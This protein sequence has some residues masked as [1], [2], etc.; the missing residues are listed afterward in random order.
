LVKKWV[1][2]FILCLLKNRNYFST[3][4]RGRVVSNQFFGD[5]SLIWNK[6]WSFCFSGVRTAVSGV[7]NYTV[8]YKTVSSVSG[9]ITLLGYSN[10]PT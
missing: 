7:F 1:K 8:S 6:I 10:G 3:V 9:S 2:V 5:F 4:V